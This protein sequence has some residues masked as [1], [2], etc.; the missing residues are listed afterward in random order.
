M[1]SSPIKN[2]SGRL[3][4]YPDNDERA[5]VAHSG[6]WARIFHVSLA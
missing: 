3:A 2:D 1:R 5:T 4:G 6:L